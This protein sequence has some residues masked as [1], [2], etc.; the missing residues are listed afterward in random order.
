MLN[1]KYTEGQKNEQLN[2]LS[3][4]AYWICDAEFDFSIIPDP[5]LSSQNITLTEESFYLHQDLTVI[6]L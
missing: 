1:M 4:Y 5:E 6:V 2:A 3:S